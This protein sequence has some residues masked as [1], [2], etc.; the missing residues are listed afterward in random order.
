M[1][2]LVL[3]CTAQFM[4]ILD[5]SVVNVA[6]PSISSAL[7]FSGSSLAWVVDAYTLTFAGFLLLGGRLA[8]L[9]GRRRVFV[10]GLGLFAATSLVGGTSDSEATLIVARALQGIGGA[11][12]APASLAIISSTFSEG[13]E[14]NRALGAWGAMG[15]VGGATGVLLGG[16]LTEALSW[17][18]I[19]F[20]NVPVGV[21][22]ALAAWR[23]V[24]AD[25]ARQPLRGRLDVPGALTVTAGLIVMVFGIVRA[26]V[27]GWGSA[28]TLGLIALGLA[29]QGLFLLIEARFSKH[30]LMPLRIL[31]SRALLGAN[32]VIFLLGAGA[33]AM[34]FFVSLYL[35]K[36]LGASPIQAGLAFLPMT[37][38][39]VICSTVA[40][41]FAQRVGAPALMA[42]GM[43]L[44]ALGL[45]MF[46]GVSAG[47][48]YLGDVLV[49]GLLAS[50]GIGFTFVPVTIVA[51]RGVAPA[52]TGLA[53]GMVN[54]S[55]QI[56]GS[57]G[58][59]VLATISVTVANQYRFPNSHAALAGGFSQAFAYG[60]AFAVAGVIV[61]LSLL[62]AT[63][64]TAMA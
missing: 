44:I 18:W 43:A 50:A 15:G 64:R 24:A 40:G 8:D 38:V 5:V 28:R 47:G 26:S 12:I 60:A 33:F 55:R 36:V 6:L 45:L 32:G 61:A 57:L 58:L 52:D 23:I 20:I 53:S 51:L 2:T 29:L 16:I 31:R 49:P 39:I 59:A 19:L 11:V 34:W 41:R 62:R 25:G 4:V 22:A 48:T 17:R 13:E 21:L 46:T 42:G 30:P 1:W 63:R 10:F 54:T 7:H 14:R 56:G 9:I 3:A 37:I 35:Q 27:W